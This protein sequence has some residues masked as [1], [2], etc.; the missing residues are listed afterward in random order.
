MLVPESFFR[1]PKLGAKSPS[2]ATRNN[3]IIY[4]CNQYSGMPHS[5]IHS[6]IHRRPLPQHGAWVLLAS[7]CLAQH[8]LPQGAGLGPFDTSSSRLKINA[9]EILEFKFK[10]VCDNNCISTFKNLIFN[11]SLIL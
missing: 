7:A 9:I 10:H 1:P 8:D 11:K 2:M 3:H 4:M 6:F 5:F